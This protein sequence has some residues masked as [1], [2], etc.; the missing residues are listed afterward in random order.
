MRD[1]HNDN[2]QVGKVVIK[3]IVSSMMSPLRKW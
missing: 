1:A 3:M 2:F